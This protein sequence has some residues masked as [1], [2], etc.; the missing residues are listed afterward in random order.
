MQLLGLFG[1]Q[2]CLFACA[3]ILLVS[4]GEA[5]TL[6]KYDP[7]TPLG[8]ATTVRAYMECLWHCYESALVPGSRLILCPKQ[9]AST[10]ST[11]AV[12]HD[13]PSVCAKELRDVSARWVRQALLY[14]TSPL[15]YW[16]CCCSLKAST[17]A[18]PSGQVTRQMIGALFTTRP[19]D[20]M[21]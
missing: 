1:R 9:M 11:E 10:S 8:L 14:C 2:R 7:C 15:T 16:T 12:C 6:G 5:A 19:L 4:F 17:S 13:I 18:L 21:G 3:S 20:V